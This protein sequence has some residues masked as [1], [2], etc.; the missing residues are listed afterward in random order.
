MPSPSKVELFTPSKQVRPAS[1]SLDQ[2]DT[3]F[4]N[5]LFSNE[6]LQKILSDD[7]EE[8]SKSRKKMTTIRGQ[9]KRR[10]SSKFFDR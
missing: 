9:K 3:E 8:P 2:E 6:M 10:R 5:L 1:D 4:T 7:G